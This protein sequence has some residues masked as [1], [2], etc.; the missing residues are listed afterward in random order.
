MSCSNPV[1]AGVTCAL[2][3]ASSYPVR[4]YGGSSSREGVVEVFYQGKWGTVCDEQWNTPDSDVLCKQLG[5]PASA[6]DVARYLCLFV[7]LLLL[8][9][10]CTHS[11]Q[12]HYLD[13]SVPVWLSGV[14]CVGTEKALTDCP[15]AG[16]GATSCSHYLDAGAT[17]EPPRNPIRL[18]G[19]DTAFQGTVEVGS[20]SLVGR[21]LTVLIS[22]RRCMLMGRGAWS[23]TIRGT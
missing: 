6:R 21:V 4:L 9:F 22:A 13:S 5:F 11:T 7:C 18:S 15:N 16:W 8:L 17:C 19:G 12:P 20:L 23:A 14:G 1:Q 3:A 2:Y 10:T